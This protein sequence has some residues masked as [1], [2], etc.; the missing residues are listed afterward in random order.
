[1]MTSKELSDL[2]RVSQQAVNRWIREQGWQT[3]PMKGVKGGRARLIV[4]S[5]QVIDYLANT[6]A[7]RNTTASYQIDEPVRGYSAKP[8]DA[9][10]QQIADVL[11]NMTPIEQQRLQQLLSR[12]GIRGFLSRLGLSAD[13]A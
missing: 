1:M 13:E 4:M 11:Q 3:V 5:P 12:E 7:L 9:T 10:W 2:V 8:S 6:T